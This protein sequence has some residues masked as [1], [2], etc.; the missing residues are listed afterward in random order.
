MPQ[1]TAATP[2]EHLTGSGV[3]AGTIAYMSP[4]QVRG[5]QL[6]SRSDLFSFGAV[7]YEM[8]TGTL[9]FRGDT[10]GVIFEAILNRAPQSA[11]RL[12]PAIPP[13]LEDIVHKALEKDPDLRYQH[14]AEIQGDMRRLQ[15][16]TE[17][18]RVVIASER[19]T[20]PRLAKLRIA[21]SFLLLAVLVFVLVLGFLFHRARLTSN[22]LT[23]K[24]TVVLTDFAN[25][26]GDAV[27]DDTLKTALSVSLRQSPFLSVLPDQQVAETLQR[28][29]RPATTE[30]TPGVT[31]EICLRAKSKAY[32]AGA[33]GSLGSEYVLGLKAV[34]CQNGNIL[35]Q[36]QV[37]A[38]TKEKV[39][40]NWAQRPQGYAVS[41]ANRWL[42]CKNSTFRSPKLRPL[43]SK[44]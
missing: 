8:C 41:S 36:Q 30:L 26:T 34:N 4:E 31:R 22:R 6:D 18:G 17:T 5:Q 40:A 43:H 27:F 32:I 35:A 14:A 21:L 39:W 29:T 12:N 24:D 25:S 11:I 42:R 23:E 3:A 1:Q 2:R 13:K 15:R 16:D 28:M 7:L 19:V 10:S 44:R 33:I 37:T 9:P 20:S 38:A